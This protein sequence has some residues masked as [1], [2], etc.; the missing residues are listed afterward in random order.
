MTKEFSIII[1]T[2]NEEST[3]DNQLSE[4]RE[5][6]NIFDIEII[7]IDGGSK[8]NTLSYCDKRVDKIRVINS[9]R[10]LQ[11]NL[12]AS[13]A[14]GKYLVFLH[15]DTKITKK[16]FIE[17]EQKS[18]ALK[19]GFFRLKFNSTKMKYKCLSAAINLRSL[20]FSYCTGDQCIVIK[21]NLFRK[22]NGFSDIRLME[23]L[24]ISKK[25]NQHSNPV[26]FSSAVITSVRRWEK[27]GYWQTIFRMR[28]LR[29]LYFFGFDTNLLKKMYK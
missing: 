12:G 6:K 8:D 23:D 25:L 24:E 13:I 19:W 9:D 5:L 17:L 18:R 7:V 26:Y 3:I 2:L 20:I 11:Q 10:A 4:L 14:D 16:N 15:A 22:I 29:L 27:F 21:K 1:P 28:C